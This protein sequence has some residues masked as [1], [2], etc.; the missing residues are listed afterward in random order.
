MRN[1]L[2]NSIRHNTRNC[3][4]ICEKV[5]SKLKCPYFHPASV[6]VSSTGF[7]FFPKYRNFLELMKT[8]ELILGLHSEVW[9]VKEKKQHLNKIEEA[10]ELEGVKYISNPRPNRRGGGA[11][12]TLIEG[13]FTLTKL[14]IGIPKRLE[15]VWGLVKPQRQTTQFK[16]ILVCSFYSVPHSTRKTKLIEHITVTYS[17]LKVKHRDCFFLMG[18]DINDLEVQKLLDISPTFHMLNTKPTYG[19]KNIDVMISDIAHLYHESVIL[20]S[21]PTDI[22]ADQ[23]GGGKPSDHPI[24]MNK[25]KLNRLEG[26]PKEV[27]IKKTRR[28]DDERKSKIWQWITRESWKM[29]FD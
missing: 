17:C 6:Q 14:D 8:Y 20:K 22:P 9:E 26:P 3:L 4:Q 1:F 28:M 12:I 11:A 23:P 7:F 29:V 21:V 24:V 27:M 19:Q 18:G 15:V 5:K 13:D 10:L 25:P 16:G 2:L